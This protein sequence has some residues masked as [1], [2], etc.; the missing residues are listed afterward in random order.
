M[1]KEVE[2]LI[3][4]SMS[5]GNHML[6]FDASALSSGLYFYKIITSGFTDTKKMLFVK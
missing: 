1:G 5:A 6:S 3:A 2:T 4:E